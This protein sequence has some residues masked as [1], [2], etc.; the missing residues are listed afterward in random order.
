M[1][2]S[3]LLHAAFQVSAEMTG[4]ALYR[5]SEREAHAQITIVLDIISS[6]WHNFYMLGWNNFLF[7]F[8]TTVNVPGGG[9]HL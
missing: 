7:S 8:L 3:S 6:S 5:K 9:A 1:C 4:S 2:T